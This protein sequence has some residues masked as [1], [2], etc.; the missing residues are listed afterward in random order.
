[1][2]LFSAFLYLILSIGDL[3]FLNLV[4]IRARFGSLYKNIDARVR[5]KLLY[6]AMFFLQRGFLLTI[7]AS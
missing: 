6:G 2:Q 7:M 1:M 3:E 5:S 4:E